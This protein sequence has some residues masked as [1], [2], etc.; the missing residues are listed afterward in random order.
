[1]ELTLKQSLF[2]GLRPD[3]VKIL[4]CAYEPMT[5]DELSKKSQIPRTSLYYSLPY[6]KERGFVVKQKLNKKILWSARTL[7]QYSELYTD[8]L[9]S[10]SLALNNNIRIYSTITDM[11]AI[12]YD[13]VKLPKLSRVYAIQP[14]ESLSWAIKK[15]PDNDLVYLNDQIKERGLIM[16]GLVHED[17]FKVINSVQL[18]KSIHG[19]SADTAKIFDQL[20]QNTCAEI[21]LYDSKSA[22]INWKEEFAVVIEDKDVFTLV[23][24][25]FIQMKETS[26]KY[27][28]NAGLGLHIAKK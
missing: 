10:R 3:H 2:L 16:D 5:I 27:D 24:E 21:Y 20:L 23:K 18:L 8:L 17:S 19:R 6:L 12:F 4:Q 1:M 9:P 26:R 15:I 22:I 25:I 13:I 28:Q 11:V 14:N 7:E